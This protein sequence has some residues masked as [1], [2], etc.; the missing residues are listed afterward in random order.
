[1]ASA[2]KPE[3]RP[4]R[5]IDTNYFFGDVLIK[6]GVAVAIAIAVIAIFTPFSLSE[7]ISEGLFEYLAVMG[8][9]GLMGLLLFM[10]GRHL[11]REATHW[12]FD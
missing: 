4:R 10:L 2:Q 3:R 11:R 8:V 6:A 12:D 1:M 7:A 9:F 5:E